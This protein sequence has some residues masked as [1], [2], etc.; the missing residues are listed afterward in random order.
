MSLV[1][2]IEVTFYYCY[3]FCDLYKN[4]KIYFKD[5]LTFI[6]HKKLQYF[7]LNNINIT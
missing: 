2:I 6:L 1:D 3:Y 7:I 4:H 5:N